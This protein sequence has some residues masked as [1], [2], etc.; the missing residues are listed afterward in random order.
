MF[1]LQGWTPRQKY[2]YS[3]RCCSDS[4][5][6]SPPGLVQGAKRPF[7]AFFGGAGTGGRPHM[8]AWVSRSTHGA[9]ERM[10]AAPCGLD[11]S[12]PLAPRAQA[13]AAAAKDERIQAELLEIGQVYSHPHLICRQ[14]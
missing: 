10:R 3:Q 1:T 4:S 12:T 11:F 9:R 8:H 7:V 5:P 6:C 13:E 14:E 2:I